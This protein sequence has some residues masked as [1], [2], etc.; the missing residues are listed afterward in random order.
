MRTPNGGHLC[1]VAEQMGKLRESSGDALKENG[2]RKSHMQTCDAVALQ[3]LDCGWSPTVDF[4]VDS[5]LRCRLKPEPS[6]GHMRPWERE[7]QGPF[8]GIT[9]NFK[10]GIQIEPQ[11][12]SNGKRG[13]KKRKARRLR[14]IRGTSLRFGHGK[15]QVNDR[16]PLKGFKDNRITTSFIF[17]KPKSFF[18]FRR[19]ILLRHRQALLN[20]PADHTGFSFRVGTRGLGVWLGSSSVSPIIPL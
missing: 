11:I 19:Q 12:R 4:T 5:R 10:T 8:S 2:E 13:K 17:P 15:W 20:F 1:S 9:K 3:H 6:P 16:R 18:N 14:L 7:T